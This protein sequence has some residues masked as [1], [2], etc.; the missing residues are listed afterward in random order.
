MPFSSTTISAGPYTPNGVTTNYPYLFLALSADEVQ[1]VLTDAGGVETILTTGFEIHDIGNPDGGV[2]IFTVAPVYDGRT[3]TIRAVPS[4]A[5]ETDFGNQGAYNPT[6][7]NRALDRA[8]QRSIYL[9]D[10]F[11]GAVAVPGGGI[12]TVT[13]ASVQGKPA[14]FTPAPHVHA[15]E[16]IT[17]GTVAAARIATLDAAKIGTG[18]LAAARIPSLDASKLT[19]GVLDPARIPAQSGGIVA[20]TDIASLTGPQQALIVEGTLVTTSDGRQW[21]YSGAGSKVLEA[22]Y[23][24]LST[25]VS[26]AALTGKPAEITSLVALS[27]TAD[28]L[29]YGSGVDTLSLT[30]FT[31]TGRALAGM[32]S[33]AAAI[34]YTSPLTTK[35]DVY[36]YGASPA[37]VPVG[38]NGQVLT[39]DSAQALGVKW[40]NPSGSAVGVN[41]VNFVATFSGNPDGATNNDAAFAAAEA[42]AYER[43]YL[44]EGRYLTTRAISTFDKRY[45]GPGKI[46]RGTSG[47]GS[48]P[49]FGRYGADVHPTVDPLVEY[50]LSENLEFSDSTYKVINAGTRRNFDRYLGSPGFP[51][52]FWAPAIPEFNR[53]IVNGGSSGFSGATTSAITAGVTTSVNVTGGSADWTVGETIGFAAAMDGLVTET[54]VLTGVN[55]L[56]WVG[57]LTN[58]YPIGTTIQ[59]G[60]RTMNVQK[61]VVLDH[62]GQGDAYAFL[63]RVQVNHVKLASQTAF[64]NGSTG[65]IIGG[66]MVASQHANYLTGWENSISNGG[67]ADIC[68]AGFVNSY[69]RTVDTGNFGNFWIHD[70]AKMDGGGTGY[71]AYGLK[72]L[73]GVYVA[74]LAA[75]TGL[76]FTRSAFSIAAVALPLNQKVSF[77]AQI[78]APGASNGNGWV[79]TTDGGMYIY[80]TLVSGVKTLE[81][82]NGGYRVRLQA[83]GGLTTNA[84]FTGGSTGAFAGNITSTGG[85]VHGATGLAVTSGQRVYLDGP[86]GNVYIDY[87]GGVV[88]IVKNGSTIFS[89]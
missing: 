23:V 44:N 73:D 43:I 46:Y 19:S 33:Q 72:P 36:G 18:T 71:A 21:R 3:L 42:S 76:D 66:D 12:T 67:A 74:A 24:L 88:H 57:P 5:Q 25:S 60:Y 70:L 81:L 20:A 38:A 48:F 16:D 41:E 64:E 50:G 82:Q 2:V 13:W 4:F 54:R 15:G 79:A 77:D 49:G 83:N 35:G 8:A 45:V 85:Y 30:P 47:A 80:G 17:S 62:N 6:E 75:K 63:A 59:H 68:V 11:S 32:A 34:A 22:S 52:Y 27:I 14:E 55:P 26:Y 1:V 78:V 61:M 31:A 28:T 69:V 9:R 10:L 7:I 86:G 56:T 53:F 87:S 65:G 37:R 40:A 39:A 89:G 58:N 84:G 29:P 51:P